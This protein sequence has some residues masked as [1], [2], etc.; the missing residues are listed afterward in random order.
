MKSSVVPRTEGSGSR[1]GKWFAGLAA[2]LLLLGSSAG[3]SAAPFGIPHRSVSASRQFVIYC[4]DLS[5]RLAISGFAEET[6]SGILGLLGQQDQWKIPIVI[7]LS[8]GDSTRPNQPIS[9][10][11]LYEVEGGTKKVELDVTLGS[12]DLSNARFQ[13]QLVRAILLSLEYRNKPPLR[14]DAPYIE[15]P[16]WLIEGIATLLKNKKNNNTDVDVYKT[17]LQNNTLPAIADFLSQDIAE[18]N[19]ASLK[20][21]Q[22]YSLGLLQLLTELPNGRACLAAYVSDLPVGTAT[23]TEDLI[24]HFPALGS[25][26]EN[27]EKWWTLSMANIA[28]SNRYVGL[29]LEETENKLEGLLKITISTG[30][31]GETK[32]FALEDYKKFIKLPQ[33]REALAATALNLHI[34]A[35]QASPVFR[36][37]VL[38]YQEVVQGL[39]RNKTHRIEE[40]LKEIANYRQMVLTRMDQ[41]ADY[42]NWFEATQMTNRSNSFDDYMKTA[43][44][45]STEGA[46]KRNDAISRYLDTL[47]LEMQ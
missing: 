25:S 2:V 23:R 44:D 27:V 21:Y 4:D 34:L 9:Q 8:R 29:S 19:A 42:L 26:G 37:V 18:M 22:A 31:A 43:R 40:H 6:K 5:A 11:R 17:L 20:L 28:A 3:S 7:D 45:L 39:Q 46:P 47:E 35:T 32:E 38:D 13:E 16:S 10:V 15:P 41:I 14:M 24:K 1:L 33:A 12:D 36:P 30:K